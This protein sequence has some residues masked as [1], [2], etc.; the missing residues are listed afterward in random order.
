M[1]VGE[2][3]FPTCDVCVANILPGPLSRLVAPIIG[4]TKPGGVIC[5]SGMRPEELPAIRL[6]YSPYVDLV[7]EHTYRDSHPVFGE[8]VAWRVHLKVMTESE[9]SESI[10]RLSTAAME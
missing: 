10:T 7:S 6:I 8:W 9:R 4:L 5:L 2:D 1:Y 3:R